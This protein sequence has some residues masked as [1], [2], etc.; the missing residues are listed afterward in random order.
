M[1][2]FRTPKLVVLCLLGTVI[3]LV[4]SSSIDIEVALASR[5]VNV[6]T[7][8][9][10]DTNLEKSTVTR[11]PIACGRL[12][13]LY[14]DERVLFPGIARCVNITASYWSLQQEEIRP[15][16]VFV[17]AVD[18]DVSI[19]VLLA[20]LTAGPY[21]VKCGGHAAFAGASSSPGGITVALHDLNEV[22]LSHDRRIATVGSGYIWEHVYAALEPYGLA[23]V[24]GRLTD[25]GV[26]GLITGGEISFY[27]NLYEWAL[28]NVESFEVVIASCKS[29]AASETS[30]PDLYWALR[31]GGNNFGNVTKFHLR[32]IPSALMRSNTRIIAEGCFPNA[33]RA[34]MAVAS[35]AHNDGHVQQWLAFSQTNGTPTAMAERTYTQATTDADADAEPPIF[36]QYSEITTLLNTAHTTTL[37]EYAT[38]ISAANPRGHRELYWNLSFRHVTEEFMA[39]A[40][41]HFFAL[42]YVLDE[43][44]GV[45]AA[46]IVQVI[47]EAVLRAMT[48][49]GGNALGLDTDGGELYILHVACYW[50]RAADDVEVYRFFHDYFDMVEAEAKKKGMSNDFVYMGHASQFQDK[51]LRKIANWY[52]PDGVYQMLQP[53]YFKL[54]GPRSEI[55]SPHPPSRQCHFWGDRSR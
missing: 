32:K 53:G 27:S 17:P 30:H 52:D 49:G 55:F 3:F 45:M 51:R 12:N 33:I 18:S 10:L 7:S 36:S 22:T 46:L 34:F 13:K 8:S 2:Y 23:V 44:P 48:R 38:N 11:C 14:S 50:D 25:P 4:S 43:I 24:G 42:Q 47:T 40:V 28:D 35:K 1:R 39:W 5:G 6:S 15:S 54:D 29:I 19:L 37:R 9:V 16:C 20:Q 26:G 21:A 31:G 41:R